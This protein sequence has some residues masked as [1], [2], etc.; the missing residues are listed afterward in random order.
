MEWS[1]DRVKRSFPRIRSL[2]TPETVKLW[3]SPKQI[4]G[5]AMM[6]MGANRS[7]PRQMFFRSGG[8]LYDLA[9]F[10]FRF[11]AVELLQ[12]LR[13]QVFLQI[14]LDIERFPPAVDN[15]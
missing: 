9:D 11:A 14:P 13:C 8:D 4:G 10:R 12:N 6:M 7:G 5:L 1:E 3:E 15:F 2:L